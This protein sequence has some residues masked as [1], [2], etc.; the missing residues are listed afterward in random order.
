MYIYDTVCGLGPT[1][2]TLGSVTRT[3]SEAAAINEAISSSHKP[4]PRHQARLGCTHTRSPV[5][6]TLSRTWPYHKAPPGTCWKALESLTPGPRCHVAQA[7]FRGGAVSSPQDCVPLSCPSRSLQ[8]FQFLLSAEG[9]VSSSTAC[10]A[11]ALGDKS[12]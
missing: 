8:S 5:Q 6:G 3:L 4:P 10:L 7:N 12:G 9:R 1:I 11:P 2:N